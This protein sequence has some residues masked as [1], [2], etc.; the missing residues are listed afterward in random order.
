M[1][2]HPSAIVSKKAKIS[3][4][5]EIGPFCYVGDCVTLQEGVK[6]HSHVVIDCKATIGADT[7]IFPFVSINLPQ[8][9]K[10]SGED[11]EVIIGKNNKIREYTTIHS[12]TAGDSLKT[13]I[14]DNC[15]FMIGSH[16]AHDCVLGNNIIMAN[17]ATLAGHVVVGDA[18]I[19]GGLSA[20]HQEVRIGVG[21]MIG[22]MSG[23]ERDVIPYGNVKCQRAFL[24]GM[25]IVGLRRAGIDRA[26]IKELASFCDTVFFTESEE[27]VL[28][29]VQSAASKYS[30][31][32][33]IAQVK[34]FIEQS[35]ERSICVPKHKRR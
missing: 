32:D 1:N 13:I 17:N 33:L 9:L 6:L 2:I 3:K 26:I 27:T 30:D 4:N 31:N 20:V 24:D 29:K 14:G 35:T 28:Q 10:F 19:I 23:V 15:L 5:V 34:E 12:G 22:G 16:I 25:N 21:A 7:E 8:D 11:S 18:A